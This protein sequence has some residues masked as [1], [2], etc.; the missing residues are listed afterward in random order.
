MGAGGRIAGSWAL[1][2]ACVAERTTVRTERT[3]GVEIETI[4]PGD[5]KKNAP[6]SRYVSRA[7]GR[8]TN[9]AFRC[10]ASQDARSRSRGGRLPC[11]ML[12]RR[13]L[14]PVAHSNNFKPVFFL[15]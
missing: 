5:G 10:F 14:F 3:M 15:P 6:L 2:C 4:R 8:L 13:L 7:L 11:T 12:V 1:N 9:F